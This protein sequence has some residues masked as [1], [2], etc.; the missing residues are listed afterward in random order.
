M[1]KPVLRHIRTA[2]YK[3]RLYC[4]SLQQDVLNNLKIQLRIA[5]KT[6][7]MLRLV[8]AALIGICVKIL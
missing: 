6:A 2:L 8:L 3:T 4:C 1:S 7:Q 5:G